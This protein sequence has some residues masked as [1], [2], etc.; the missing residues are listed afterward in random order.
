[1]SWSA[2]AVAGPAW[3]FCPADRP[4][5]YARAAALADVVILDLEDAVAPPAKAAA[6]EAIR[7]SPLDPDRA[8]IRSNAAGTPDHDLDR[9]MLAD[10]GLRGGGR[11][12]PADLT[13]ASGQQIIGRSG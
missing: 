6:R 3:L 7:R 11:F 9:A 1:M 5:R 4:E 10:T 2:G 12:T 13:V 8:V